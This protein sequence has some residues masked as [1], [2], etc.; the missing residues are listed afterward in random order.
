M[1]SLR[2][3]KEDHYSKTSYS[4]PFNTYNSSLTDFSSLPLPVPCLRHG[5]GEYN[6]D[7][8]GRA[9]PEFLSPAVDLTAPLLPRPLSSSRPDALGSWNRAPLLVHRCSDTYPLPSSPIG[10]D[11]TVRWED[12]WAVT[13][14]SWTLFLRLPTPCV[15]PAPLES[16]GFFLVM[17]HAL[18]ENWSLGD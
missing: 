2:S 1:A 17:N 4:L 18:R 8:P 16:F 5:V 10:T 15:T 6:L 3:I 12:P 13:R 11:V 7:V 14:E 9:E